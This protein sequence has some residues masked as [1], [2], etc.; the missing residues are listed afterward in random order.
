MK[1]KREYWVRIGLFLLGIGL[2]LL[3]V[4]CQGVPSEP[5][6]STGQGNVIVQ[7]PAALEILTVQDVAAENPTTYSGF[8]A[9]N[10]SWYDPTRGATFTVPCIYAQGHT[11]RTGLTCYWEAATIRGLE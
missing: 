6:Q 10:F 4:A 11:D 3:I 2:A 1:I 7:E 8:R 5:Q 9:A